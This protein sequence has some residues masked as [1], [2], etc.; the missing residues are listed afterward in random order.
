[1]PRFEI[2]LDNT[3]RLGPAFGK[4][5]EYFIAFSIGHYD[6]VLWHNTDFKL[7]LLHP[8]H[9]WRYNKLKKQLGFKPGHRMKA[10]VKYG[11]LRDA[12]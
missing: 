5:G 7:W 12:E 2:L 9:A 8:I 10:G 6:I 3:W 4:L 1:M 11:G